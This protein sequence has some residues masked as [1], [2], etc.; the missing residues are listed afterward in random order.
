MVNAEIIEMDIYDTYENISLHIK[1]I[2]WTEIHI[3]PDWYAF[4]RN[5]WGFA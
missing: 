1:L 2:F 5:N 4:N 3:Q